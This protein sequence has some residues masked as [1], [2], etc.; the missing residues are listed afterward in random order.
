MQLSNGHK[1]SSQ[2]EWPAVSFSSLPR[3]K[4]EKFS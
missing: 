3:E 1:S 2:S 4:I